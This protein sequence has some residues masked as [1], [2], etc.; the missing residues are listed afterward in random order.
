M[1]KDATGQPGEIIMY[2]KKNRVHKKRM[3][4]IQT[5]FQKFYNIFFLSFLVMTSEHTKQPTEE[6]FEKHD[7][8]GMKKDKIVF[9]EQRMIPCFDFNGKIILE[10]PTKIARAPDGN[11]GLYWALKNEGILTHMEE[12]NIQYL[13]VYCVDNVLVK[14]ADPVFMGFC[15]EKGAESGEWNS[16][17]RFFYLVLYHPS[18]QLFQAIKSC[19]KKR[20]MKL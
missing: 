20:P 11:G 12:K 16:V 1:A 18:M 7:Y 9:F 4:S 8:F 14:V 17:F 2:G 6:F 5:I 3:L 15:I 19:K 10:N 13:H